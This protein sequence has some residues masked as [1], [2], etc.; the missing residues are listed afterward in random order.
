M[1]YEFDAMLKT[2]GCAIVNISGICGHL[3]AAE[4]TIRLQPQR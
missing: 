3:G 4:F 2:G 1:K